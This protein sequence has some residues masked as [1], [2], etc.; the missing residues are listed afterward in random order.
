M[1]QFRRDLD[2]QLQTAGN[3]VMATIAANG[4]SGNVFTLNST[5]FAARLVRVNQKVQ[6]YS[7]NLATNRGS[8]TIQQIQN[9]LG[10]TP[11]VTVDSAPG[12]TVATDVLVADGLSGASP[13]GIYGIPLAA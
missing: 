8:C 2:S 4:V 13:T 6:V 7:A 1:K 9:N 12:G 11:T 3:A 10:G 5:P